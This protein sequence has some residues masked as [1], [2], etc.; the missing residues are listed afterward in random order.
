MVAKCHAS[1]L[2]PAVRREVLDYSQDSLTTMCLTSQTTDICRQ[3][4]LFA[5]IIYTIPQCSLPKGTATDVQLTNT[6]TSSAPW[7]ARVVHFALY[8]HFTTLLLKIFLQLAQISFSVV[9]FRHIRIP[10]LISTDEV[11]HKNKTYTVYT[12]WMVRGS[13]PRIPLEHSL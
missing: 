10:H 7:H 1:P 6:V 13:L 11:V 8:G 5:E 2:H 12:A 9:C 4:M 3:A